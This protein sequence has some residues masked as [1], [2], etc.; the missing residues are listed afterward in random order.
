MRSWK[1]SKK[2]KNLHSYVD[3]CDRD[4]QKIDNPQFFPEKQVEKLV[5]NEYEYN[6]YKSNNTILHN[7]FTQNKVKE[8]LNTKALIQTS[9]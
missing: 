1:R 8:F 6:Q 5:E 4:D 9:I 3:D 2:E 7:G